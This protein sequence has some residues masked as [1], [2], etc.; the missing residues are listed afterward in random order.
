MDASSSHPQQAPS[1]TRGSFAFQNCPSCSLP[2]SS[3]GSE[4]TLG[5]PK[6]SLVP[7][8]MGPGAC[9]E[10]TSSLDTYYDKQD[11]IDEVV[12]GVS[13]H[14]VVHDL[15]PAFQSNHLQPEQSRRDRLRWQ[16]LW[17]VRQQAVPQTEVPQCTGTLHVFSLILLPR[18]PLGRHPHLQYAGEELRFR[19]VRTL[20]QYHTDSK[21]WIGDF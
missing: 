21:E 19:E 20:V 6:D 13:I 9:P 1:I 4:G 16:S 18:A 14:H 11:K 3:V 15:H 12:E 2:L 5:T 8:P 17:K 10:S 7:W